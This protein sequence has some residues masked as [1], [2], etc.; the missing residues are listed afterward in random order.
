MAFEEGFNKELRKLLFK[1]MDA[2]ELQDPEKVSAVWVIS[3]NKT[4]KKMSN[5]ASSMTGMKQLR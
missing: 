5:T 3:L 1:P 4:V 2:Q